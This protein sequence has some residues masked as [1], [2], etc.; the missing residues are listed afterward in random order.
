MD[1][2]RCSTEDGRSVGRGSAEDSSDRLLAIV[3]D[4]SEISPH[5][6]DMRDRPE[7]P[8]RE[9]VSNTVSRQRPLRHR[10]DGV[11]VLPEPVRPADLAIDERTVGLP[12]VDLRYPAHRDAVYMQAIFDPRPGPYNDRLQSHELEA[13]PRRCDLLEVPRVREE[14]EYLMDGPMDDLRAIDAMHRQISCRVL[15]PGSVPLACESR[16]SAAGMWRDHRPRRR[17]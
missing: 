11:Q 2:P 6:R 14:L 13:Q 10:L 16:V 15:E 5:Q 12:G 7:W 8:E 1:A 17:R 3:E 9:R 4:A